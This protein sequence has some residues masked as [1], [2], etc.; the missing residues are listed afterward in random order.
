MA[1]SGD[2]T[3]SSPEPTRVTI[4]MLPLLAREWQ[5][6]HPHC[7][8]QLLE[9]APDYM[10][11]ARL[12]AAQMRDSGAWLNA[13]PVSAPGLHMDDDTVRVAIGLRLEAWI[14]GSAG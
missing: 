13:L 6:N 11:R 9:S 8:D 2:H 1:G 12:L 5:W 14:G 4:V 7:D 3:P 10:F